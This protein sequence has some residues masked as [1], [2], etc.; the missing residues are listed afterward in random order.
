MSHRE[1]LDRVRTELFDIQEAQ[2]GDVLR[3]LRRV[4]SDEY[5]IPHNQIETA[6]SV[7]A[8]IDGVYADHSDRI[9]EKHL[10]EPNISMRDGGI[11]SDK[12]RQAGDLPMQAMEQA[13]SKFEEFV[14]N[15]HNQLVNRRR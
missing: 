3:Y 6:D 1:L 11:G 4:I 12:S 15:A 10:G 2:E 5:G 14:N 13:K 8:M 9:H 7:G